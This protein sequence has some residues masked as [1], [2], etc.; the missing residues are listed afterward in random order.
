MCTIDK[1]K[2]S[3]CIVDEVPEYTPPKKNNNKKNCEIIVRA[4]PG[5]CDN[6]TYNAL[7]ISQN[8]G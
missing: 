6:F 3:R 7:Y 1:I 5:T 2:Y 4:D 8:G